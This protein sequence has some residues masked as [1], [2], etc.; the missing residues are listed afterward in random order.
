MK[1]HN[2]NEHRGNKR[3]GI[4]IKNVRISKHISQTDLAKQ[5]KFSIALLCQIEKGNR[6]P[7]LSS[8]TKITKILGVSID[9]LM[10]GV[11]L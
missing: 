1:K 8:L 4:G 9:A 10:K 3:L 6:L 2:L 5:C 11:S 7:S